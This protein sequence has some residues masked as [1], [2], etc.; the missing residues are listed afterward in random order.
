MIDGDRGPQICDLS[1]KRSIRV[2]GVGEGARLLRALLLRMGP[3]K[4]GKRCFSTLRWRS[5]ADH[6]SVGTQFQGKSSSMRAAGQ[7]LTRRLRTSAR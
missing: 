1:T 5:K 6:A 2:V 3:G 7:R 4:S